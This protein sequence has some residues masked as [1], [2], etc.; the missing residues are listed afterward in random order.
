MIAA[1]V[2]GDFHEAAILL[3]RQHHLTRHQGIAEQALQ[4]REL[5]IDESANSRS[6]F[7]VTASEDESH[8]R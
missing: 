4:S 8:E 7:D 1:D 6:D 5:A 2:N 3:A